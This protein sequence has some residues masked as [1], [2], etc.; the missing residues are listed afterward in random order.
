MK[1]TGT[2]NQNK[3]SK[4]LSP[5]TFNR[6]L[7]HLEVAQFH[8]SKTISRFLD[9]ERNQITDFEFFKEKVNKI[10]DSSKSALQISKGQ[11]II[12]KT[13]K[14]SYSDFEIG[15]EDK[16]IQMVD[17]ME[18]IIS[19]S[20]NPLL[21]RYKESLSGF[22]LLFFSE[23]LLSEEEIEKNMVELL[24]AMGIQ[25]P[26]DEKTQADVDKNS[27][28]FDNSMRSLGSISDDFGMLKDIEVIESFQDKLGR[29]LSVGSLELNDDEL[30]V[31]EELRVTFRSN[32]VRTKLL[33]SPS[34]KS[35]SFVKTDYETEELIPKIKTK[36]FLNPFEF[37]NDAE[38][39]KI[40]FK[41]PFKIIKP[42]NFEKS[43]KENI[44]LPK[45][46]IK[47]ESESGSEDSGYSDYDSGIFSEISDNEDP[48]PSSNKQKPINKEPLNPFKKKDIFS[49]ETQSL[50]PFKNEVKNYQNILPS[51]S[52]HGIKLQTSI[53]NTQIPGIKDNMIS[54]FIAIDKTLDRYVACSDNIHYKDGI[55]SITKKGRN[56]KKYFP[57][58]FF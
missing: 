58:F 14:N 55:L 38:L 17:R 10:I 50:L 27:E 39:K 16:K 33:R 2:K 30:K 3:K 51:P 35:S 4:Q 42:P 31:P 32:E 44:K 19:K 34:S 21:D 40:N 13:D 49:S 5:S 26:E 29:S 54:S 11:E 53:S 57:N 47:E 23:N 20:K 48:A 7:D 28:N 6:V 45:P 41:S 37:S 9:G 52:K 43:K 8:A 36:K 46:E 56:G 25:N 1:Y 18:N 15:F 24:T 22:L 12:T